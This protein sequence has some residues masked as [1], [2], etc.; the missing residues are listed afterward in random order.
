MDSMIDRTASASNISLSYSICCLVSDVLAMRCLNVRT[1]L[2]LLR[3]I[4]TIAFLSKRSSFEK[5]VF[6][7]KSS[8]TNFAPNSSSV[9][10]I[11]SLSFSVNRY[12]FSISILIHLCVPDPF[13]DFRDRSPLSVHQHPN[14]INPGGNPHKPRDRNGIYHDG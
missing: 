9:A 12:F 2:S 3:R 5:S 4:L 11:S 10:S 6:S 1:A 13:P 14:A 7:S 8:L